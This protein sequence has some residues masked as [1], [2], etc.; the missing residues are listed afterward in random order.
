MNLT[1]LKTKL[2]Y[3][4]PKAAHTTL[5]LTRLMPLYKIFISPEVIKL[6]GALKLLQE[7]NQREIEI[8]QNVQ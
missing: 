3:I 4:M 1:Q 7:L 5:N 6:R 8:F 2:I